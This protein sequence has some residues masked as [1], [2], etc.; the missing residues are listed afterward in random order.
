MNRQ[1]TSIFVAIRWW[2]F[3]GLV[4]Y[5]IALSGLIYGF[6]RPHQVRYERYLQ[7]RDD[8]NDM[9]VTLV[10]LD[11][12]KTLETINDQLGELEEMEIYFNERLV[13]PNEFNSILPQLEKLVSENKMKI[14]TLEPSKTVKQIKPNYEKYS[15]KASVSGDLGQLLQ[16]LK[17]F[18]QYQRW[19]L[20]E[21]LGI[22]SEAN[23]DILH[24][25]FEISFL[26][27]LG[28]K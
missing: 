14:I 16:L 28:K 25:D 27:D 1:A 15:I 9:Y 22:A 5:S 7:K 8:I 21:N 10:N 12:K 17:K 19:L 4:L 26:M 2:F 24:F 18:E 20:I 11:I 6:F 3:W 23:A 13:T